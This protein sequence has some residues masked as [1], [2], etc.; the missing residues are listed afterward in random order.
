[1]DMSHLLTHLLTKGCLRLLA[2]VKDGAVSM[3]I[4]GSSTHE[5]R[6]APPHPRVGLAPS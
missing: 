2:V 5:A 6:L 1:M 3:G 4:Q